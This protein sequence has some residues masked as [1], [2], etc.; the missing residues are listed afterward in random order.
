[1]DA[2]K[3][4]PLGPLLGTEVLSVDLSSDIDEATFL[5]I[6]RAFAEHPVL[7]FPNQHL[8]APTLA[9][10]GSRFGHPQ[11]H[12]L[13]DYRH[14]DHPMVSFITNVTEDG[15]IDEFGVKRASSW[16]TD[17]TWE[18]TMPRLAILHALELPTEK[19][20]TLFADMRAA[21][22]ALPGEL[23]QQLDD[24]IALHGRA[25]GP[26]GLRLYGE[27]QVWQRSD[28]GPGQQHPAV[29]RHP[30][31]GRA[32]LFVNPTHTH[33][34]VGMEAEKAVAL[35][36]RLRDHAIQDQFVY[37]HHWRVGD[38]V[39]WDEIATMHRS[40]GDADPTQR[41]I[42]LRTIVRPFVREHAL[43]CSPAS[44]SRLPL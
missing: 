32:V 14:P 12:L 13:K 7:V 2:L 21:Y 40:A 19:G 3:L 30:V 44:A 22:D 4:R 28:A 9:A 29:R 5:W 31:T 11:P 37:Y 39:M 23:K 33:G 15:A 6:E 26:D 10:F 18:A 20:G 41:R 25:D 16:H 38:V 42:M 24:L 1:M 34:F 8:G 27:S 17:E 35:I 43:A 36:D